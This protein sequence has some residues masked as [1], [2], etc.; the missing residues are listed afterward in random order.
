MRFS[1][2]ASTNEEATDRSTVDY[3]QATG[4]DV[5][6]SSVSRRDSVEDQMPEMKI[7]VRTAKPETLPIHAPQPVPKRKQ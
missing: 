5:N 6:R 7:D 4:S 1:R 2:Q 3:Y